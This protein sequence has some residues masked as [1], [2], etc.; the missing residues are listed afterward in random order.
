MFIQTHNPLQNVLYIANELHQ[1]PQGGQSSRIKQHAP[2]C[3]TVGGYTDDCKT[4]PAKAADLLNMARINK[5]TV[6]C[7][8]DAL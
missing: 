1:Q 4:W 7:Q 3:T 6:F 2:R 8:A 5:E